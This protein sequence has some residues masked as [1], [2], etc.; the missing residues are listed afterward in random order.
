[1]SLILLAIGAVLVYTGRFSFGGLQTEGRHVKAAGVM[2]MLPAIS[3][4]TLAVLVGMFLNLNNMM[5]IL[6]IL[7]VI[8]LGLMV[9]GVGVAYILLV[10][11]QNAPRLPGLLGEIQ[12]E[13]R[14]SANAPTQRAEKPAEPQRPAAP[15]ARPAPR[16]PL[17]LGPRPA[18]APAVRPVRSVLTV[19]EAANYMGVNEMQ[20][21]DWIDK[22]RLTAARDKGGFSIA[23]SVLDELKQSLNGPLPA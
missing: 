21:M 5:G 10:D 20:I 9:L 16:H 11:P 18:A 8:E 3:A 23:R 1:M 6:N 22:G 2:L 19:K 15:P 12:A 17:E 14:N 13:R 7:A 4:F